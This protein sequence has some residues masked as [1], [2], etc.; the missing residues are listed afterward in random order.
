MFLKDLLRKYLYKP[1]CEYCGSI[2]KGSK[3]FCEQCQSDFYYDF[4]Q[5]KNLVRKEEEGYTLLL[6]KMP[7][8]KL[9]IQRAQN[10]RNTF[11]VD[12]IASIVVVLIHALNLP[13]PRK[14]IETA[15]IEDK[16]VNHLF[17][18]KLSVLLNRP[19]ESEK[20]SRKGLFLSI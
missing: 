19:V 13:W 7:Y 3:V 14:L 6:E 10:P 18:K 11:L 2:L 16:K 20:K 17:F 4:S 9:L 1:H 5:N 15:F 8:F 12:G